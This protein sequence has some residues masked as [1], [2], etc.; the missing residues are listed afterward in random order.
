MSHGTRGRQRRGPVEDDGAESDPAHV[1]GAA[2]D[3]DLDGTGTDEVS[4]EVVG[5]WVEPHW[6][7]ILVAAIS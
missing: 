6:Q 4:H 5:L 7:A 1:L 3:S 2:G